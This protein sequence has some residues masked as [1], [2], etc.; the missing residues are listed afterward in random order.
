MKTLFLLFGFFLSIALSADW[1]NEQKLTSSD[2]ATYDYFGISVS[3]D[4]DYAVIGA[5]KDDDN[6]YNSGSAYV[7]LRSGTTWE[8]Q[9]KLTPS[10]AAIEDHIGCSV[11]ID[12]DYIVIGAFGD[13][14]NGESSG[15][16]YIF[17]RSG[18]TW[19][20]QTKITA[21]DGAAFDFF[22]MSVSISGDYVVIGAQDDDD[23]GPESGSVY[24]FHRSGTNWAQQVKITAPDGEAEDRF[25]YS[26]SID[27]DYAVVGAFGDDDNGDESGSAYVY[28][29]SGTSWSQQ[30]KI[31]A[32][33]AAAYNWFSRS[34]SISEDYLVI[35]SPWDDDNGVYSGSAYLFHRSGTNWTEQAKIIASDGAADDEFGRDVSIDGDNVVIGACHDD[36]NG[37]DSGSAYIFHRSET[38]WTEQEKIT[39]SDGADNDYFGWPVSISGDHVLIGAS[40]DDDN[41]DDSG[42]AYIYYNDGVFIEEE[43]MNMPVNTILLGNVPNPFNLSTMISFDMAQSSSFVTLDIHNSRGQKVKTLI[44]DRLPPGLHSVLW[45]GKDEDN[46]PVGSGIYFYKLVA[47]DYQEVKNMILLK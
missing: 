38:S 14:D 28:H 8:E 17:V 27:G 34:V 33:D 45:D 21:S 40:Y 23:N 25:G 44:S 10:G 46:N 3:V 1:D 32:S 15:S 19:T 24:V 5:W 20:Q 30:A 29:R 35:G 7:F 4:G 6:A 2:A 18:I 13:D 9:A 36:D 16:A 22:G 41:G 47:G 43:Q 31:T 11:A 39:A 26:V 12:G 42:S 37:Y